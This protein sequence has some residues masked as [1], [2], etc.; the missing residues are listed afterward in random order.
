MYIM[1][2]CIYSKQ[3]LLFEFDIYC[4]KKGLKKQMGKFCSQNDFLVI[5]TEKYNF[6]RKNPRK[7]KQKI[8]KFQFEIK[9]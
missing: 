4:N 9:M 1:S 7:T 6:H 5:R 2:D 8:L 3:I